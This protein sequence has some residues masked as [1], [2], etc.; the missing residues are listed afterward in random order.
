MPSV[1]LTTLPGWSSLSAGEHTITIKAKAAGYRDSGPSAEVQ[2][3][4]APQGYKLTLTTIYLNAGNTVSVHMNNAAGTS[5][6]ANTFS[7]SKRWAN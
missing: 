2:V 6:T 3:T 5:T 7:K 4:K 1:D